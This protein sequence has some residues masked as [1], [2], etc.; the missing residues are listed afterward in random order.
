MNGAL[1]KN[2]SWTGM[3]GQKGAKKGETVVMKVE[4]ESIYWKVGK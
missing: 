4:G 1:W 2:A 3:K